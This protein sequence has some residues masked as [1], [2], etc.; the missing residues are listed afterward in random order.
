MSEILHVKCLEY[1]SFENNF[2]IN[3]KEGDLRVSYWPTF[4]LQVFSKSNNF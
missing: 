4:L 1:D 3:R 2:W